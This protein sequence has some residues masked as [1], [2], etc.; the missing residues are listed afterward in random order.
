MAQLRTGD[1]DPIRATLTV[2]ASPGVAFELFTLGMGSWWDPAYTPDATTFDGIAIEPEVGAP[3]AMLHGDASYVVGNVTAWEPGQRYAQTFWL[4]MDAAH[5][6]M[7]EAQFTAQESTGGV[8]TRVEFEH[9]GWTT[10]NQSFRH[11]YGDWPHLLDRYTDA[12]RR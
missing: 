4:A 12:L 8:G 7:L 9:G 10:A 1:L 5:P 3:V 11:K 6:S 2:P